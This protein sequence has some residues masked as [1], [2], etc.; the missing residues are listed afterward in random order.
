VISGQVHVGCVFRSSTQDVR[1]VAGAATR[2]ATGMATRVRG[3][4]YGDTALAQAG[5]LVWRRRRRVVQLCGSRVFAKTARR[6]QEG[7]HQNTPDVADATPLAVR[8]S[9]GHVLAPPSLPQVP[10]TVGLSVIGKSRYE[11]H[12]RKTDES[13]LELWSG[14]GVRDKQASQARTKAASR[15]TMTIMV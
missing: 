12:R 15:M 6:R 5:M 2:S 7:R 1:L 4:Q 11:S 8:S 3:M 13:D 14:G 10:G 9:I